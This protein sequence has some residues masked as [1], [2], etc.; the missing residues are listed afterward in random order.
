MSVVKECL[1]MLIG[2]TVNWQINNCNCALTN[3]SQDGD[4]KTDSHLINFVNFLD[5]LKEIFDDS[6]SVHVMIQNFI[7]HLTQYSV[8]D[9]MK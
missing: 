3:K 4:I 7:E 8:I 1:D 2:D 6:K 5:G 9:D